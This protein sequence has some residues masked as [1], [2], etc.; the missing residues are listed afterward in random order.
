MGMSNKE[1][2]A[3]ALLLLLALVGVLWPVAT[4]PS[5]V[6]LV[7]AQDVIKRILTEERLKQGALAGIQTQLEAQ[8]VPRVQHPDAL[9]AKAMVALRNSEEMMVRNSTAEGDR[10]VEAA[11]GSIRSALAQ[12]PA[13][14][15]LWLLLY[16][17]LTTRGGFYDG[18][19]PFL[20]KS[21]ATGPLEG[22]IVLRRNRLALA[23]FSTLSPETQ[24]GALSEFAAM[25]DSSFIDDAAMN[26]TGVGWAQRERLLAG[27]EQV[28]SL[29]REAFAKKLSRDGV[30]VKVPGV[31]IEER[32]WRW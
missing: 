25:V 9:R 29:P 30:M 28:D 32:P 18:N 13:D 7:P 8:E 22:W 21:Y 14:S 1:R 16:S 2:I 10:G 19:I 24:Q 15:F 17:V 23:V 6:A 4:L 27:L 31:E 5:F 26:L 3:R 11:E 20:E 12:N